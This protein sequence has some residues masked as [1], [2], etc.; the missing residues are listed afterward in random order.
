MKNNKLLIRIITG[1]IVLL[2]IAVI[3]LGVV[4]IVYRAGYKA[5]R[6]AY[7]SLESK[8]FD[9]G[10]K[11]GSSSAS[12]FN[13]D[14][15]RSVNSDASGWLE[16][17]GGKISGPVVSST[18]DNYY[19]DHRFDK[20]KAYCGTF[21]ADMY[22]TPAFKGPITIV[23]GHNMNDGSMFHELVSYRNKDYLAGHETFTLY[24]DRGPEEY[25]IFSVIVSDYNQIPWIADR[26]TD[27]TDGKDSCLNYNGRG[28]LGMA[29]FLSLVESRSIVETN[30]E[31]LKE[32]AAE[33]RVVALCTCEVTGTI[34][35]KRLVVYGVHFS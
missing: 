16:A 10:D 28:G 4:L 23:Y 20:E 32:N 33:A 27:N 9:R 31:G 26:R 3:T 18:D 14:A 8:V 6:D 11:E 5:D 21:F 12:K 15:L 19:L 1:L 29:D 22:T 17:C 25:R 2:G 35:E 24:T 34:T 7:K 13:L 30:V